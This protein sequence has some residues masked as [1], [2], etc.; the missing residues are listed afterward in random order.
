MCIFVGQY[1]RVDQKEIFFIAVAITETLASF[2]NQFF[3]D[4]LSSRL[5]NTS[6][7]EKSWEVLLGHVISELSKGKIY[8]EEETEELAVV[9]A[10]FWKI[11]PEH[12]LEVF[13]PR[14]YNDF[15]LILLKT[16]STALYFLDQS[17][18]LWDSLLLQIPLSL[19]IISDVVS[20]TLR[21]VI[22]KYF[23]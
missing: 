16:C 23:L 17:I 7:G 22:D 12:P 3:L 11:Y 6:S 21:K 2:Y 14:C 18:S 10:N 4:F 1:S 20:A 8:E 13:L 19:L 5:Q 9:L 15:S